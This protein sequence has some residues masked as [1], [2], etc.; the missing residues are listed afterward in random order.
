MI[1][2]SRLVNRR[3]RFWRPALSVGFFVYPLPVA[4]QHIRPFF[5]AS[6]RQSRE[7]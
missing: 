4:V 2:F 3:L 1:R 5:P 6:L 7:G